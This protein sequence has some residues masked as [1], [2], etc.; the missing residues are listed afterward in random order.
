M[1]RIVQFLD[2]VFLKT[3]MHKYCYV[4]LGVDY[5]LYEK[6]VAIGSALITTGTYTWPL[7]L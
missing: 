6:R 7:T 1:E 5:S 4:I 3:W 2:I